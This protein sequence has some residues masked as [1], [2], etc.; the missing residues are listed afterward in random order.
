VTEKCRILV[1]DDDKIL[2]SMLSTALTSAGYT[3][4]FVQDARA[5]LDLLKTDGFDV[6]LVDLV[7]P[8][9][10][11]LE[12]L[13]RF[14][15]AG[16][17]AIPIIMTGRGAIHQAVAAIKLGAYDF[18]EKSAKQEILFR[19]IER[20][21]AFKVSQEDLRKTKLVNDELVS[22]LDAFPN[23]IIA[24]DRD[25]RVLR[26]NQTVNR[27]SRIEEARLAGKH[28][29][30][31]LCDP[32]DHELAGCPFSLN[33]S[34]DENG[35]FEHPFLDRVFEFDVRALNDPSDHHWGWLFHGRD[36]TDLREAQKELSESELRLAAILDSVLTGVLVIDEESRTIVNAN[37]YALNTIGSPKEKVIGK[38]CEELICPSQDGSCPVL[39]YGER[40]DHTERVLINSIGQRIPVL[41]NVARTTITGKSLLIESFLDISELKRVEE[42]LR[43]SEEKFRRIVES[44]GLGVALVDT[45]MRVL[46]MNSQMRKWHPQVHAGGR[47]I[48]YRVF[49]HPPGEQPCR[50]CPTAQCLEDGGSHEAVMDIP[51]DEEV[52]KF[53]IIASPITDSGGKGVAA[54]EIVEDITRQ[55]Q[56]EQQLHQAQKLESIGQLAAGI[57]H[58]INTPMQFISDNTRFLENAFTDLLSV[59]GR[60]DTLLAQLKNG[61]VSKED[62]RDLETLI[63]DSDMAFLMEEIPGAIGGSQEGIARVTKIVRAMKDFSHPAGNELVPLDINKAIDS[64][65]TVSRNE[66]KYVS[67]VETDLDPSQ[68]LIPCFAGP[69]NQVLLNLIV[70]AA[71][72]IAEKLG[73]SPDEKGIIRISS[74][75]LDDWLEIS[76]RDT[77]VGIPE[78]LRAR[79]FDPFF[80]TKAIGKGTGQGLSIAYSVVVEQHKGTLEVESDVGK[81]ANFIIRLPLSPPGT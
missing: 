11:G 43:A 49:K 67:N 34:V 29:H 14:K 80:T 42:T 76:V 73:P 27:L 22:L 70:N 55:Y 21:Y 48:C 58:E 54:I 30:E 47:P 33:A 65:I 35:V 1:V 78:H 37:P 74:R 62:I 63:Q 66:W 12:F 77:G 2:L 72:A 5:A 79:I 15:T 81:G 60:Y 44:I 45:D 3:G 23:M 38:R 40:I 9:M 61:G 57:A 32:A 17:D 36:T 56:V 6:V 69:L 71:Q 31:V 25:L 26:C 51:F 28:I 50:K 19:T 53:R 64:T 46:E 20:A 10:G 68:P 7:M 75:C 4:T 24:T 16:F 8:G 52:R 13:Q 41:K 59:L 39:D 18:L